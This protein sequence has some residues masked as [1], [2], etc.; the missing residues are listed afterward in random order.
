MSKL[1]IITIM[2]ILSVSILTSC[3]TGKNKN[4]AKENEDLKEILNG[5]D[6]TMKVLKEDEL[7]S[8]IDELL[9]QKSY[10]LIWNID[11]KEFPDSMNSWKVES[12]DTE[13]VWKK[14]KK[15]VFPDAE[16]NSSKDYESGTELEMQYQDR[17]ISVRLTDRVISIESWFSDEIY[18]KIAKVLSEETGMDC[19]KGTAR[20]E[21]WIRE[22]YS[23]YPDEYPIDIKGY[24]VVN[25]WMLGAYFVVSRDNAEIEISNP[26]KKLSKEEKIDLKQGI[27]TDEVKTL[28]DV[29]WMSQ[30]LESVGVIN[31]MELV[32]SISG[33]GDKLIPVYSMTGKVYEKDSAGNTVSLYPLG[34]LVDAVTGEIISFDLDF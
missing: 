7:N 9:E 1:R 19:V 22:C 16:I 13:K 23:F 12:V 34:I 17:T 26:L 4:S 20:P 14:I 8:K 15:E 5:S 29:Q 32:Y 24:G 31:Q 27:Q 18:D 3:S 28:C 21:L 6:Q 10:K 25:N 30:K 33:K 2:L 11:E